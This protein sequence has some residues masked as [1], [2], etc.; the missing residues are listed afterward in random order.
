MRAVFH[1]DPS[2]NGTSL[3][4]PTV[5]VFVL[6]TFQSQDAEDLHSRV[7]IPAMG[8]LAVPSMQCEKY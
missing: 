6:C 4:T 8:N 5:L 3:A 7:G 1:C 2:R